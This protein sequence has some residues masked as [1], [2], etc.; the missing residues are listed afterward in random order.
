MGYKPVGKSSYEA[1]VEALGMFGEQ[2]KEAVPYL[3]S[4]L[5]D[6]RQGISLCQA[7]MALG[8]I[9]DPETIPA[10]I[11]TLNNSR[12]L[13]IVESL[14]NF[15]PQAKEALPLLNAILQSDT[16]GIVLK[17]MF[18]NA[19]LNGAAILDSL[20]KKGIIEEV[21]P[22]EVC[23]KQ[24]VGTRL[25]R[26]H[27]IAGKNFKRIWNRLEDRLYYPSRMIINKAMKEINQ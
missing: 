3:V 15:G 25:R 16:H 11:E 26:P 6:S 1:V 19:D 18:L 22:T 14:G 4:A 20:I 2:A 27:E 8:Q 12:N 13:C 9:K 24:D 7:A 17:S 23:L 21:S 10:L 5:Q